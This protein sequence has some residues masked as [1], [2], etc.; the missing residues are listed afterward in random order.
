MKIDIT[1]RDMSTD[2]AK[3]LVAAA[4]AIDSV[5]GEGAAETPALDVARTGRTSSGPRVDPAKM[6]A[7]AASN[8]ARAPKPEKPAKGGRKNAAV[9]DGAD[10]DEEFEENE[11]GVQQPKG[12]MA[13][14]EAVHG[15]SAPP[16]QDDEDEDEEEDI[17]HAETR[18]APK[19]TAAA[20]TTN[21]KHTNGTNGKSH[22]RAAPPPPPD[23]EDEEDEGAELADELKNA[24]KLRD[25][26]GYLMDNGF[27]DPV[28]IKAECNRL[29][30]K[31]GV[32]GRIGDLDSRIERTL[33]VMDM[34]D[35]TS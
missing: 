22:V 18:S 8:P 2:Q 23:D 26:L 19:K 5:P 1:V 9:A 12:H 29:K 33:E 7:I 25:V 34:G 24:R 15:R 3:D 6:A 27:N 13:R 31:V 28:D 20:A 16:P 35:A 4:H 30:D 10:A 11:H 21:G 14:V 17:P 32:L